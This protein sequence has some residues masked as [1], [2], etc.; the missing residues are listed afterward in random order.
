MTALSPGGRGPPSE[1]ARGSGLRGRRPPPVPVANHGSP[2][3]DPFDSRHVPSPRVVPRPPPPRT[4]YGVKGDG[5]PESR[6]GSAGPRPRGPLLHGAA[7][8]GARRAVARAECGRGP[9]E[10]VWLPACAARMPSLAG[11]ATHG[12]YGFGPPPAR[13]GP[14]PCVRGRGPRETGLLGGGFG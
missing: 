14:G 5:P 12:S 7:A 8:E 9:A 13:G 2:L 1:S 3:E 11:R 4:Y 6:V 10:G